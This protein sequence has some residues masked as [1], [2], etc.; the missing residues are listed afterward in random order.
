MNELD[1]E[2]ERILASA[3]RLAAL[4]GP[5][6]EE[7]ETEFGRPQLVRSTQGEPGYWLVP[8]LRTGRIV[9]VARVLR[10]GSIA[11]VARLREAAGDVA[12]AVTG[13]S[14]E[15]AQRLAWELAIAATEVRFQ[16]PML[17]Y[18]GAI[19]REAWLYERHSADGTCAWVLATGGGVST[20]PKNTQSPGTLMNDVENF[21]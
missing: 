8:G 14:E 3:R 12:A 5:F 6:L 21:G 9:A 10:D 20:R 19:G 17:V 13:M 4:P 7:T 11:S 2:R 18:D 16:G 1:E 15:R